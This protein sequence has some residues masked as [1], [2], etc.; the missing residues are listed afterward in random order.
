MTTHGRSGLNRW[1]IGS[2]TEE[3]VQECGAPVL[4]VRI[5]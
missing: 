5:S 4:L 1:C 2:V 3:V